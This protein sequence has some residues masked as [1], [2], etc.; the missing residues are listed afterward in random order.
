[1][2]KII[3]TYEDF[4]ALPND[5][6][7]YELHEGELSVTPSPNTAHQRVIANLFVILRNHVDTNGLGEVF[8]SPFD[9]SLSNITVVVPDLVYVDR[10][11]RSLVSRRA[12]EGSPTLAVEVLS[13]STR[14]V[15]RR[16]K[17]QLYALYRVPHYWIVDVDARVI[18]AHRLGGDGYET[19]GR[20]EGSTA[21][22]LPPFPGL[23]LE[24]AAI[25]PSA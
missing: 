24:P 22:S 18:D 20:L 9:C 2:T 15:D 3:L 6:R 13:P 25:W 8:L 12:V 17:M 16:T 23:T 21:A 10:G 7:R 4:A 14:V 11:A 1:M 19:G 5:G